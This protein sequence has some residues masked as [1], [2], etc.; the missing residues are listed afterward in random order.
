[1]LLLKK[2]QGIAD[3]VRVYLLTHNVN[4]FSLGTECYLCQKED[5]MTI[6]ASIEISGLND[7]RAFM[8]TLISDYQ[9]PFS[10]TTLLKSDTTELGIGISSMSELDQL[11][12]RLS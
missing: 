11:C 12:E 4:F 2:E 10:H 1:L 5:R 7:L 3:A 9:P 6:I 8:T